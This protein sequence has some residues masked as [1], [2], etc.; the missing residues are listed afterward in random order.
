MIVNPKHCP[1]QKE[2]GE[3]GGSAGPSQA[4]HKPQWSEISARDSCSERF[5]AAAWH[6]A[7]DLVSERVGL[8]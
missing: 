6:S 1:K 7:D 8:P 4:E 2:K 5:E 3:S